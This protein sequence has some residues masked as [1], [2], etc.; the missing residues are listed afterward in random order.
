M[1]LGPLPPVA[2]EEVA[3]AGET[4]SAP[5]ERFWCLRSI[6]TETPRLGLRLSPTR[7]VEVLAAE[8]KRSFRFASVLWSHDT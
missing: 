7:G 1:R 6:D 3:L 5:S 8:V 4:E 2:V